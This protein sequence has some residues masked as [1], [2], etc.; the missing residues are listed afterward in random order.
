MLYLAFYRK[1]YLIKFAF[2]RKQKY[3]LFEYGAQNAENNC[4]KIVFL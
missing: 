1:H 4:E 3:I 2:Y